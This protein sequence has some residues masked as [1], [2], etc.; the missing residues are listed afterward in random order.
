MPWID[1]DRCTG[2]QTCVD[3]C[4]VDAIYMSD[5]TAIIDMTNCI[6]CGICHE[7]C[8][9][10]AVRHDSEKTT[11]RI[12]ENIEETKRFM[13]DCEQLLGNEKEGQKCLNR[14]IKHFENERIIA[15][16]TLEQLRILN[17]DL[18]GK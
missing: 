15:E 5:G 13:A 2:C 11:D 1:K 17:S 10:D 14:M 6:R 18:E 7:V 8:P 16:R 9:E 4:P 3:E 12:E